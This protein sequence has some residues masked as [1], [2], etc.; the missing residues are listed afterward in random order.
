MWLKLSAT[1]TCVNLTRVWSSRPVRRWLQSTNVFSCTHTDVRLFSKSISFRKK[2]WPA[3]Q[4]SDTEWVTKLS[5]DIFHLPNKVN[6]SLQG[7]NHHCFQVRLLHSK[8]NWNY[9]EGEWTQGFL[10][11]FTHWL[12]PLFA[13][14]VQDHLS[15]I[16]KEFEQWRK[17]PRTGK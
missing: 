11:C 17:D 8:A 15:Q 9:G 2:H 7:E 5:G 1:S 3:T 6:I 13:Q 10:T 4:F 16:S 14:L 12:R